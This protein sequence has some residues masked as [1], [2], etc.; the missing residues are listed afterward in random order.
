M[1]YLGDLDEEPREDF[2]GALLQSEKRANARFDTGND[3]EEESPFID[4]LI[5]RTGNNSECEEDEA[6]SR[7]DELYVQGHEDDDIMI[8]VDSDEGD[9]RLHPLAYSSDA[10][11]L[12]SWSMPS[13]RISRYASNFAIAH[14]DDLKDSPQVLQNAIWNLLTTRPS[15]DMNLWDN[16]LSGSNDYPSGRTPLHITATIGHVPTFQRLLELGLDVDLLSEH[17]DTALMYAAKFGR[18]QLIK[19]LLKANADCSIQD[20]DGKIAFQMLTQDMPESILRSLLPRD[21]KFTKNYLHN[22][23]QAGFCNLVKVIIEIGKL[24]V[25]LP[26]SEGRTAFSLACKDGKL[27]MVKLLLSHGSDVNSLDSTNWTPLHHAAHEGHA[28]V[29]EYL[30]ANKADPH[31]LNNSHETPLLEAA[32]GLQRNS[33]RNM[34]SVIKLLLKHG[35]C[36]DV[37]NFLGGNV[38]RIAAQSRHAPLV[39]KLLIDVGSSLHVPESPDSAFHI[40]IAYGEDSDV[41]KILLEAEK[42]LVKRMNDPLSAAFATSDGNTPLH[43]AAAGGSSLSMLDIILRLPGIDIDQLNMAGQPALQCALHQRGTHIVRALLDWGARTDMI[44]HRGN[45]LL[46]TALTTA[47]PDTVMLLVQRLC[48]ANN[49]WDSNSPLIQRFK[50][51]FWFSSLLTLLPRNQVEDPNVYGF[52]IS[53]IREEECTVNEHSSKAEQE[54]LKITL[55]TADTLKI[56]QVRYSVVSHDQGKTCLTHLYGCALILMFPRLQS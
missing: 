54:Y 17:K 4:V 28:E 13:T 6:L 51:F 22:A 18:T 36:V 19:E 14:L 48:Q 53:E 25:D 23:A 35:S 56:H 38:L 33:E 1:D 43:L 15:S 21:F 30:L 44:D 47:P 46:D 37:R 40:A 52:H 5:G 55:P 32:E 49:L 2:L 42:Q 7:P 50:A 11:I 9:F 31:K 34:L 20:S 8:E 39:V 41:F 24:D 29:V 12:K 45:S 10:D 16:L 27:E 26:N 3:A